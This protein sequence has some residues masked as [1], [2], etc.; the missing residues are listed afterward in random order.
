MTHLYLIRHAESLANCSRE[1]IWGRMNETPLSDCGK[2]QAEELGKRLEREKIGFDEI[3]CSPAVRTR[4]TLRYALPGFPLEEVAYCDH[5]QELD[6]GEW[7]GKLKREI[8]TPEQKAIIDRDNWNF[9]PLRGESQADVGKRM[10]TLTSNFILKRTDAPKRIA[11]FTH[12]VAIKCLLSILLQSD[13]AMTWRW[14]IDNTSITELRYDER[15]WWPV[16]IN[17]AAHIYAV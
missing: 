7:V 8:Y 12:G 9:A 3:Y 14:E 6:Q 5:L 17:D 11:F 15:L 2:R 1:Y 13:K 4:E 16:R 10:Y